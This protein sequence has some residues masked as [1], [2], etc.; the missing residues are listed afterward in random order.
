MMAKVS[1]SLCAAAVSRLVRLHRSCVEAIE[2]AGD[3]AE[4]ALDLM[5]LRSKPQDWS[6]DAGPHHFSVIV[7]EL[8]KPV[9]EIYLGR[10]D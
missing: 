4:L 9:E 7:R 2:N 3:D 5:A 6:A 1:G 10:I 8:R